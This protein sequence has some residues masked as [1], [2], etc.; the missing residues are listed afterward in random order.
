MELVIGSCGSE[1]RA[2]SYA[3][4][5]AQKQREVDGGRLKTKRVE[6]LLHVYGIL[7]SNFQEEEIQKQLQALIEKDIISMSKFQAKWRASVQQQKR[8]REKN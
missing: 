5:L 8:R 7:R 1:E 2:E 6:T 3:E 4:G